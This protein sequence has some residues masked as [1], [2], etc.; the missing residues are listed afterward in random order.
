M[1]KEIKDNENNVFWHKGEGMTRRS[2]N[3]NEIKKLIESGFNYQQIWNIAGEFFTSKKFDE[4][5]N[6]AL[7]KINNPIKT[8]FLDNSESATDYMKRKNVEKEMTK[9]CKNC[10]TLIRDDL[11]FCSANCIKEYREKHGKES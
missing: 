4:Y 1:T 9:H 6:F 10:G 2:H 7:N 8:E 3:I 5:Y 11:T